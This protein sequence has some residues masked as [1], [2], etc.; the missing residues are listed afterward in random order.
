MDLWTLDRYRRPYLCVDHVEIG[1]AG[2]AIAL[3]HGDHTYRLAIDSPSA[4]TQVA[5]ELWALR[6]PDAPA[7]STLRGAAADDPWRQ[8]LSFLDSRALVAEAHDESAIT[9]ARRRA[10]VERCIAA[11]A[12]AILDWGPTRMHARIAQTAARLRA[13]ADR[14]LA[15]Q[16]LPFDAF[17]ARAEPNFF[18]ALVALE[19]DYLAMS[20]PL[21]LRAVAA[22]LARLAGDPAAALPDD[23]ATNEG[24]ALY[25]LKD[26]ESH[27]WLVGSA[28]GASVGAKAARLATAP[29][30]KGSLSSG[31]E[32]M[33]QVEL[34]TR[35]TLR[36]WGDNLYV[37]ALDALGD[38]QAPLIAGP[39]I[40]QYHVTRRFVEIIA[41][42]LKKRLSRPLR[43]LMFQYFSEEVGHEALE[44]TTCEALGV[45][46]R[47]LDRATPLPLHFAFV[48]VLTLLAELDPFASF[49]SIMAIE[50]VFGE[51]PRVSLRL[52]AI[53][54]ANSAFQRVAGDHDELNDDLNHNSIARDV[55]EHIVA[56]PPETQRRVM[57]RILF[58][59][60]LNHRA[61]NDIAV[62][63]GSQETLQLPGPQGARLSPDGELLL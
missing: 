30:P 11:T 13:L 46:Q 7:W 51:P 32:F 3:L 44:S 22:L 62:F 35:S 18:V 38:A 24:L 20:A 25:D 29:L 42:L 59:L 33:R 47:G 48:D 36:G 16:V 39:F 63:Y 55:F 21:T 60:E 8:V 1:S 31:L 49:C 40:E 17:D 53:A 28:V 5:A 10:E 43:G 14:R 61:W 52:A 19:L 23:E 34:L 58:L 56:A 57:R 6:D 41:P 50:G 15:A 37:A 9:T 12:E 26:L 2:R 45:S 4:A 27:L 54:S